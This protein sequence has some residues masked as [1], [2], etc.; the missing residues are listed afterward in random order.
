[1]GRDRK[2]NLDIRGYA[3]LKGITLGDI[4]AHIG[5]TRSYFSTAYMS[6][7]LPEERKLELIRIID[8]IVM[9][10]RSHEQAN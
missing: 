1:M 8:E 4:A 9:E 5:V 10:R 6:F 2:T 7:E 3:T